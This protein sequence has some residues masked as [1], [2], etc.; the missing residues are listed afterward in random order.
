MRNELNVITKCAL[1]G[2]EIFN[3]LSADIDH[4]VKQF[5]CKYMSI[6]LDFKYLQ[7]NVLSNMISTYCLDL[8]ASQLWDY[9][10]KRI[11][12]YYVAWRNVWK[13][14]VVVYPLP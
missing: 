13:L 12:K 7:C 2:I 11:G 5:N 8:Y 1:L 4:Y 14:P 3:N 9:E 10:D 6:Y